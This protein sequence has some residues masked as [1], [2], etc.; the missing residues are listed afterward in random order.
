MEEQALS[1][2][3]KTLRKSKCIAIL[4]LDSK[5]AEIDLF[6]P[7]TSF[8]PIS[9][10]TLRIKARGEFYIFVVHQVAYTFN[11]LF[12]GKVSITHPQFL[13]L[14]YFNKLPSFPL[15]KL[16]AK[17]VGSLVSYRISRVIL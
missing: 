9:L 11:F 14:F 4:D 3:F 7:T 13:F 16:L 2:T 8:S 10:K 1:A 5:E 15:F 6:F 17:I 12:I